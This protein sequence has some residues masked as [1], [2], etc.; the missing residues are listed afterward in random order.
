MA[1]DYLVK[2]HIN[3]GVEEYNEFFRV[4]MAQEE[5]TS[6]DFIEAAYDWEDPEDLGSG[7]YEVGEVH[8][9]VMHHCKIDEEDLE[10]LHKYGVC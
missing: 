1:A 5:P 8:V 2:M 6:K 3:S 10:T 4:Y 7:V 9:Y